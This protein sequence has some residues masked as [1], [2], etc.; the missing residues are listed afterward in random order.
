MRSEVRSEEFLEKMAE[1]ATPGVE[2]SLDDFFAKRDK[3][4]KKE[5]GKGKE[6]GP[7]SAPASV[8][9]NKKEKEKS[10]KSENQDATIEKV[11]LTVCDQT[12]ASG[13]VAKLMLVFSSSHY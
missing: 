2:K 1:V 6:A 11:D 5:K 9:K 8:K 12:H 7:V 3:K 4:K 13:A 10:M